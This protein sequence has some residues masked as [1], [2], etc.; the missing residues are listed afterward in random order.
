MSRK[1]NG[2][3]HTYP[4]RNG[5][6]TVIKARG[7]TFSATG[8]TE[9]ESR[10]KAKEKVK[11]S[12]RLNWGANTSSA[13]TTLGEFMTWWLETEHCNEIAD[14][15]YR[16]YQQLATFHILPHLGEMRLVKLTRHEVNHLLDQMKAAGQSLRSAQ[17]ARA[18][19]SACL[20]AAIEED[21]IGANP[22]GASRKVRVP[23]FEIEPL[24]AAEVTRVIEAAPTTTM[25]LRLELALYY[26][27]RQG[28][29]LGLRWKR[30]NFEQSN[31][32]IT[33][34]VQTVKGKRE[35]VDLKTKSSYR[36]LPLEESTLALMR[37]QKAEVA[38]MRLAA[39]GDWNDAGLVFPNRIGKPLA[40][41]W[42]YE[43]WHRAL[44]AV[45]IEKRRL[46]D[47][48]HTCA[49]LMLEQGVD[50]EVIRYWL[51]H[52][53][54]QLTSDTYIHL[55]SK[56]TQIGVEAVARIKGQNREDAA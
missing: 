19:L 32:S 36:T 34:Q 12:E 39:G 53:S 56:T 7:I 22:V 6:R 2:D 40:S 5:F 21:L 38:A 46:H 9:S 47:A 31:M 4:F 29:A 37:A 18:L 26:G 48:R 33:Q 43:Q 27:L 35:L 14:S 16:R 52:S 49:T 1:K 10:R 41:R 8:K 42:D 24:S 30:V 23:R 3:G 54:V 51:G 11:R 15:T 44:E 17:Q 25:K 55:T 50:V 13:R 45:G 20:N 28:E